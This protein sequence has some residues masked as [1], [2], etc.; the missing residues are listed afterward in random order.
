MKYIVT[1]SNETNT[2]TREFTKEQI[3]DNIHLDE[4]CD[5]PMLKD[6]KIESIEKV[7]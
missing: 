5:S 4:L 1:Y 6:Y 3:E 2:F 7:K